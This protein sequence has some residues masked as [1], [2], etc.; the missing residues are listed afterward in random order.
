MNESEEGVALSGA[1]GNLR[2][3]HLSYRA[4]VP[5]GPSIGRPRSGFIS[6]V[7]LAESTAILI[8]RCQLQT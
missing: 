6:N 1:V 8:V 4:V 5:E 7:R 3:A 2:D